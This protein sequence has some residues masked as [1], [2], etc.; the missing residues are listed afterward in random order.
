MTEAAA[1]ARSSPRLGVDFHTFDGIY[2]GSRSHLLGLYRAAIVQAPD[3]E[4]FFFLANPQALRAAHPEFSRPNTHLIA[5]RDRP[6]IWRLAWQLA[7]MQRRHRLDLLHV[8][9]RLPLL[10]AG[11]QPS[12]GSFSPILADPHADPVGC[13]REP[14]SERPTISCRTQ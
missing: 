2:Q 9:Y 14:P 3:I 13:K 10:P 11:Q 8:Q 5:M 12:P 1:A 4:F 7:S 6:G